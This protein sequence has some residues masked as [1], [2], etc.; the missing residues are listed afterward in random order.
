MPIMFKMSILFVMLFLCS[1]FPSIAQISDVAAINLPA[2]EEPSGTVDARQRHLRKGTADLKFPGGVQALYAFIQDHLEYPDIAV[3]NCIEGTVVVKISFDENGN[4]RNS[5]ILRSLN[6]ECDQSVI[7]LAGKMPRWYPAISNG[8][9][10][11]QSVIL[12][13]RFSLTWN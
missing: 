2:D 9:P 6:N 3:E 1:T 5:Y 10:V 8:Q 13:V 7:N 12:P 4:V 11:S